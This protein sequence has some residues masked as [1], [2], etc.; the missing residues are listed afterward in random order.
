MYE[1]GAKNYSYIHISQRTQDYLYVDVDCAGGKGF[2][3]IYYPL[4]GVYLSFFNFDAPSF[5]GEDDGAF[6]GVRLNYC[7]EGRC[8]IVMQDDM[9]LFFESDDMI[10]TQGT[11]QNGFVFPSGKYCGVELYFQMPRPQK[12]SDAFL[13]SV[14]VDIMEI[15]E[16]VTGKSGTYVCK[17]LNET[18]TSISEISAMVGYENASKFSAVFKASTGETPLEYRRRKRCGL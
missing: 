3:Q 14:G 17:A 13:Q 10:L 12:T 9:Y 15:F 16:G 1:R 6:P 7:Y 2:S 8:E 11:S 18:E 4:P 5:M